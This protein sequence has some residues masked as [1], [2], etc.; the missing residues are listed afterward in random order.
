MAGRKVHVR[1]Q[2]EVVGNEGVFEVLNG[3]LHLGH[4][5]G[6]PLVNDEGDR[7]DFQVQFLQIH[8]GN[9]LENIFVNPSENQE[10]LLLFEE[11]RKGVD[12]EVQSLNV[13]SV[14]ILL[15]EAIDNIQVD[16]LK[17]VVVGTGSL[18][19]LFDERNLLLKLLL[20]RSLDQVEELV[21]TEVFLVG[22]H[23]LEELLGQL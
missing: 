8:E 3:E 21:S 23:S 9:S 12:E 11:A 22:E 1:E 18:N 16:A 2:T 17:T 14:W 15:Q 5:G 4:H 7:V 13:L 19:V 6:V 10:N 20:Q